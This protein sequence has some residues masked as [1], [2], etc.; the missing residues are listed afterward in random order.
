MIKIDT[1][2]YEWAVLRGCSGYFERNKSALPPILV[3]VSRKGMEL[4]G[5][6]PADFELYLFSYGYKPYCV[7]GTHRLKL[8]DIPSVEDVLFLA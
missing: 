1:E 4:F 8:A 5:I 6:S 7:L 3:E 2:G